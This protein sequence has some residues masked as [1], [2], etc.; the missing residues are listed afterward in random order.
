VKASRKMRLKAQLIVLLVSALVAEVTTLFFSIVTQAV[1]GEVSPAAFVLFGV[2]TL[3]LT[4]RWVLVDVDNAFEVAV[5]KRNVLLAGTPPHI[6]H[7]ESTCPRRWFV[8][9]HIQLHP[10]LIDSDFE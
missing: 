2:V 6:T 7:I 10:E 1:T 8:L 5:S 9:L 4:H 3:K